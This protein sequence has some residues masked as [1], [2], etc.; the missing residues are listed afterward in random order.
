MYI[1]N[2]GMTIFKIK[3]ELLL[4]LTSND[5]LILIFK[6]NFSDGICLISFKYKL[7]AFYLDL[8]SNSYRNLSIFVL[9]T[10]PSCHRSLTSVNTK[11]HDQQIT[12]I[13][14]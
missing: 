14:I 4:W 11:T 5:M 12:F 13:S 9:Y 8:T 3:M 2:E 10:V 7:I 6:M 1:K